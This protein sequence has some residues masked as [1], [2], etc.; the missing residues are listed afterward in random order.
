MIAEEIGCPL[1]IRIYELNMDA[2]VDGSVRVALLDPEGEPIPGYT[3]EESQVLRG[4]SFRRLVTWRKGP[5]LSGLQERTN[6]AR[7]TEAKVLD[8]SLQEEAECQMGAGYANGYEAVVLRVVE[9]LLP[10]AR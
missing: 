7:E 9:E 8:S 4:N 10:E 2:G 5:D 3:L 1:N 6:N